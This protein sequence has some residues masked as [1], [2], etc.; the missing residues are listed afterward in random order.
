MYIRL[1]ILL[2]LK[3]FSLYFHFYHFLKNQKQRL[4]SWFAWT[5]RFNDG[6][7]W[8]SRGPYPSLKRY[9]LYNKQFH[10]LNDNFL[11]L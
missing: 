1:Q 9:F 2:F 7:L 8:I 4:T 5:V 10:Q 11:I 3:D 6:Q